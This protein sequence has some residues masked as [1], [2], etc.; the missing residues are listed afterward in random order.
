MRFNERRKYLRKPMD[1]IAT[2]NFDGRRHGID[3]LDFCPGG[4]AV[5]YPNDHIQ[6]DEHL[7][8]GQGYAFILEGALEIPG[9]VIRTFDDGFALKFNKPFPTFY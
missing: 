8:I 2:V 3:I 9:K 1:A 6:D 4:V 5:Q 7:V